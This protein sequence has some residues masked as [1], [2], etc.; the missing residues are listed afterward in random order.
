M[1]PDLFGAR[2]WFCG[3]QF[4]HNG[5]RMAQVVMRGMGSDGGMVLPA[6][7]CEGLGSQWAMDL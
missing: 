7:P 3:G 4:F 2:D 1:G 5:W 6:A